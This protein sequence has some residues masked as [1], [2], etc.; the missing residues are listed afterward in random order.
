MGSET[1]E[2]KEYVG[3]EVV[4]DTKSHLVYLGTLTQIGEYFV[5][6]TQCDVHDASDSQTTKEGYIHDARKYGVKRNR[7]RV[8]VRKSEIISISKLEDV[9]EY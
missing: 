8:E 1:D 3:V 9:T 7:E 5:T 2:L 6:L 4:L